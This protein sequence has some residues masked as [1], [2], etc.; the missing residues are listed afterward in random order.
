ML[1][2]LL[3]AAAFVV[4]ASVDAALVDFD[5]LPV[6]LT[7][8]EN[9]PVDDADADAA[10]LELTEAEAEPLAV[11]PPIASVAS[12]TY[13]GSAVNCVASVRAPVPH[14]TVSPSVVVL[15]GGSTVVPELSVMMKRPV[16]VT[17]DEAGEVNW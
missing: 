1:A 9:E 8:T 15:S 17:L 2:L 16:Q 13:V 11:A 3:A 10:E 12:V 7:A 14:S 6:T 4:A 5:A